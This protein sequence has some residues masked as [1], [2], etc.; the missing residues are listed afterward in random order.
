MLLVV[1]VLVVHSP[2][3]NLA[4]SFVV[5][6]SECQQPE[7]KHSIDHWKSHQSRVLVCRA[8]YCCCCCCCCCCSDPSIAA[9]CLVS[10]SQ[11]CS[12]ESIDR[13][14]PARCC[15]THQ[16]RCVGSA[17]QSADWCHSTVEEQF[18]QSFQLVCFWPA[19]IALGAF[20]AF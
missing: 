9:L 6:Y 20:C 17:C 7:W 4:C 3:T 14:H 18:F 19:I 11:W 5:Q 12:R 2:L 10:L 16:A 13:K 8:L 1:V 15:T